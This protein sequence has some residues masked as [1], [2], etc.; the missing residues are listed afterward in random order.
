MTYR[1]RGLS[2]NPVPCLDTTL[3]RVRRFALK[4]QPS[5]ARGE[6]LGRAEDFGKNGLVAGPAALL[7]P[8]GLVLLVELKDYHCDGFRKTKNDSSVTTG[9]QASLLW[10]LT[11]SR[12]VVLPDHLATALQ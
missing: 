1:M 12:S 9:C 5:R 2:K 4:R 3:Q 7:V 11:V 6:A 10:Q 8:I